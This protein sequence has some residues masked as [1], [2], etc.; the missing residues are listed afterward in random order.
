MISFQYLSEALGLTGEE[1][2]KTSVSSRGATIFLFYCSWCYCLP[3]LALWGFSFGQQHRW[4]FLLLGLACLPHAWRTAWGVLRDMRRSVKL[5]MS[6]SDC[7]LILGLWASL[8]PAA[9]SQSTVRERER[10]KQKEMKTKNRMCAQAEQPSMG[11]TEWRI[12]G[13]SWSFASCIGGCRVRW[14]C[15]AQASVKSIIKI[16]EANLLSNCPDLSCL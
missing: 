3:F 2:D 11:Q 10:E 15:F 9:P 1:S 8:F 13:I 6:Q 5:L 16:F 7:W 12:S 14:P 4:C